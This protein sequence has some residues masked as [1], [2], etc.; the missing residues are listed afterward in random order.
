[1][2]VVLTAWALRSFKTVQLVYSLATFMVHAQPPMGA[3]SS[4]GPLYI[5]KMGI[6]AKEAY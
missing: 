4:C 3:A 2:L 5:S 1:M 6:D